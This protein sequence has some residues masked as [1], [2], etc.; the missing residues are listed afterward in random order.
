MGKK[1]LDLS[2]VGPAFLSNLLTKIVE[3]Q[4][5]WKDSLRLSLYEVDL[6]RR[7]EVENR[8]KTMPL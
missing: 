8:M 1:A 5:E 6:L 4:W 2:H 3:E 7:C